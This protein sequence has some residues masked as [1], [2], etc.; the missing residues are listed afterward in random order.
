MTAMIFIV[1]LSFYYFSRHVSDSPLHVGKLPPISMSSPSALISCKL[2]GTR[3]CHLLVTS[4]PSSSLR[5]TTHGLSGTTS[6]HRTPL[7]YPHG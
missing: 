3:I 1:M 6:M 2:C 5:K 4:I 7:P